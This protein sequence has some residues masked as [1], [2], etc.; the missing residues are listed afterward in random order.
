MK[1][2]KPSTIVAVAHFGF[3]HPKLCAHPPDKMSAIDHVIPKNENCIV[4]QSP[5]RTRKEQ[6][7]IYNKA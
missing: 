5:K 6:T 7:P 2:K 4:V 3:I 1:K